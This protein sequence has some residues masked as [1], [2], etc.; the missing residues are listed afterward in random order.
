MLDRIMTL[1][2]QRPY[3]CRECGKRFYLQANGTETCHVHEHRG[4]SHESPVRDRLARSSE[5]IEQISDE[6]S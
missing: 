5:A 3:K 4:R 1:F 2:K 6:M